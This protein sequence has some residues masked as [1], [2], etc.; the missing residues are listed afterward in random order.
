MPLEQVGRPYPLYHGPWSV[1]FVVSLGPSQIVAA[2]D[3]RERTI[4]VDLDQHHR[5]ELAGF[6]QTDA[7]LSEPT[8]GQRV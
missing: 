5:P 1:S 7:G 4:V 3:D 6:H 2:Q 8:Q